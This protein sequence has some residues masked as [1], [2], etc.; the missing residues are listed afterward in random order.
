MA[1]KKPYQIFIS[2][3][4]DGGDVMAR[5]LY[6]MLSYKGYRVFYDSETM[7]TGRFDKKIYRIIEECQ[8]VIIVLSPGCLERCREEGDWFRLE[9]TYAMEKEKPIIP[10]QMDNFE[11]PNDEAKE[12][13]PEKIRDFLYFNAFHL[14]MA[15]FEAHLRRIEKELH[16]SADRVSM[17]LDNNE[18]MREMR[19]LLTSQELMERLPDDVKKDI[20]HQA[21]WSMLEKDNG[22]MVYDMLA[23]YLD[24]KFN[25]R[26][27]FRYNI[28]LRESFNFR[29]ESIDNDK[30]YQM[31][32]RLSY[33]KQYLSEPPKKNFSITFT[34]ELAEL[35]EKLRRG[36]YLFSENLLI[37]KEDIDVLSAFNEEEKLEFYTKT[38]KVKISINGEGLQPDSLDI[39]E[40]GILANYTMPHGAEENCL[41]DV[42]I[43]FIMPHRKGG[44][45]F[46]ASISEPTYS[47]E[48]SFTYPED[49]VQVQMIPFLN[50]RIT[51]K[52][53]EDFDGDRGFEVRDE[54]VM[55]MSGAVF[56]IQPL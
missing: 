28:T 54:W 37:D 14:S 21:I 27:R 1:D 2:Y 34:T 47:P 24:K 7:S 29:N 42:K 35:D 25:I 43:Q 9:I 41:V 33:T 18:K 6:E 52:G 22:Q 12:N 49:E 26:T 48:V 13:Y 31:Q 15:D 23:P 45:S 38:M 44:S 53:A 8:D 19:E 50:Q 51:A 4:R 16:S 39:Q 56:I 20:I 55:P 36:D 10:I 32:E 17:L 5:F 30:Y 3:R 46:F 11:M 40:G